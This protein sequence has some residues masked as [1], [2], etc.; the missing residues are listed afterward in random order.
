MTTR[1]VR[2]ASLLAVA[3][4][5][6]SACGGSDDEA[7]TEETSSSSEA[8]ET[9][10]S[11]ADGEDAAAE[12]A[13]DADAETA[14][15]ETEDAEESGDDAKDSEGDD[16]Q[17]ADAASQ[18]LTEPGTELTVGD[19]ATVPQ[20][21]DG[22]A[23]TLTV[24]KIT[25]GS[26]AD[27]KKLEDADKYT[28]Y[29]PVYVQYTMTG[30]D[31]SGELGGDILDDVDPITTDGAKAGTL[32]IIGTSPFEKCDSNSIPDDFGPGDTETTCQVAM[33]SAGQEIG[34]AQYAPY[35]GKYSDDGKVVWQQ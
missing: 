3:A 16:A 26:A 31:S 9:Q 6:L 13:A 29:T 14:D 12:D 24:T 15:A 22:A 4:L 23:I 34:G 28:D 5:G 8:S 32:V 27:L 35:E 10:E 17:A 11:A 25:K 20:G 30:T 7:T 19:K 2:A 18:E 33:L 21:D 1:R